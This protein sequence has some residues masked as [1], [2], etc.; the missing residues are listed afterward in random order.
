MST[1]IEDGDRQARLVA[2]H[3]LALAGDGDTV[4]VSQSS[5]GQ[6]TGLSDRTLRRV[7]G[8]LFAAGWLSVLREGAGVSPAL[9]DVT[10]ARAAGVEPAVSQ[11]VRAGG[12]R[13]VTEEEARRP[14]DFLRVG[15]RVLV[16]PG[17]LDPGSNIRLNLQLTDSLVQTVRTHGVLQDLHVRVSLTGLVVHEGH[18]RHAAALKAGVPLVPVLVVEPVSD[19]EALEQQLVMN[20][21]HAHVT[22]VERARTLQQLVLLGVPAQ[23]IH[24][25]TGARLAEVRAARQ[26]CSAPEPVRTLGKR[27]P[28]LDLVTLGRIGEAADLLQEAGTLEETLQEI[29]EDPESA[30]HVLEWARKRAASKRAFARAA[31]AVR[32]AGTTP[33]TW[34]DISSGRSRAK[35]LAELLDEHGEPLTS[36]GHVSCPG[37][38]LILQEDP[39]SPADNPEWTAAS[40]ACTDWVANGHRN[41]WAGPAS[42]ATSGPLPAEV[43]EQRARVR[44]GN[45]DMEA[46]SSVRR[47]WIKESLLPRKQPPAGWEDLVLQ[48]T[49]W[50]HANVSLVARDKGLEHLGLSLEELRDA[51]ARG[52]MGLLSL[53]LAYLEGVIEKSSWRTDSH[54]PT[55][56]ARRLLGRYLTAL[57]AWGYHLAAI[58]K[59][60]TTGGEK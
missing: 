48:V 42:G 31:D 40:A 8:R 20:D 17:L 30:D 21:E 55:R 12:L 18:R 11:P 9:Y 23:D 49:V 16:P 29:E 35:R 26:V 22:S 53:H 52:A 24:R 37:H 41:R 32:A 47:R 3:V 39:D 38:A 1:V 58:E 43:A 28:Q 34:S 56:T 19:Q 7:L 10:G 25:R 51:P 4:Q 54:G 46:A 5:L 6:V 13:V 50:A 2:A 36:E 44:R 57:E 15:D 60:F 33:L 27:A 45:L 59:T 14:A